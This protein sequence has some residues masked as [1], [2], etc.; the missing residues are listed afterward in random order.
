MNKNNKVLMLSWEYP[1][2]IIGGLARVVSL[3]S[4]ELSNTGWAVHVVTADHPDTPEYELDSLVNVHRVKNQT[5]TTPDFL[6]WINRLNIGL[7][8]YA[9]KLHNE[10]PFSIIHAH[11]WMV[12]DAA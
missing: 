7:L 2:R 8:Q 10:S 9:I 5:E 3:L 12:S 6:T 11:D 4:K 1:P